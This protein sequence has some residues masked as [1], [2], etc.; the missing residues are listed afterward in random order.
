MHLIQ[1]LYSLNAAL[2]NQYLLVLLLITVAVVGWKIRSYLLSIFAA[3]LN[4]S[5][6]STD[7]AQGAITPLQALTTTLAGAVGTGSIIG[8][9][10]AMTLGGIGALFWMW[11]AALLTTVIKYAESLLALKYRS[12][13]QEKGFMGSPMH[14]MEKA[15]GWKWRSRAFALIG[16]F[17]TLLSFHMVQANAI[18]STLFNVAG[19]SPSFS[20]VLLFIAVGAVLFFGLRMLAQVTS[21]LVPLMGI[22]YLL[23][24]SVILFQHASLLPYAFWSVIEQAFSTKAALGAASGTTLFVALQ[25]GF[26]TSVF[27]NEAGLG[28]PSI[29]CASASSHSPVK[30]G[31]VALLGSLITTLVVCTMTGLVIAVTVVGQP[32]S[33]FYLDGRTLTLDIF[34]QHLPLGQHLLA[35]CLL[36]FAY[37][38][39]LAWAYYGECCFTHLFSYKSRHLYRLIYL[40][41]LWPAVS[42]PMEGIWIA[43]NLMNA[44][45]VLPNLVA[46]L[47]L[48][49]AVFEETRLYFS[50]QNIKSHLLTPSVELETTQTLRG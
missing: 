48:R 34:T 21:Y 6:Q 10:T 36:L 42:L 44:L 18:A 50:K 1:L 13:S 16:I 17:S 49:K 26:S 39:M 37:S 46:L 35:L 28:L 25:M 9:A 32:E 31:A 23:G 45:L 2:W 11:V 22:L 7:R 19:C 5:D 3:S 38:T 24:G 4:P 33:I 41:A 20:F 47:Y 15:L 14:Y 43:G 40:A 8:V 30:M 27:A 29:A 12:Q